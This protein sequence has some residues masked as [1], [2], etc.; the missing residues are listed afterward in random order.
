MNQQ[1]QKLAQFTGIQRTELLS[2]WDEVKANQARLD[3]CQ[4]H[5]FGSQDDRKLGARYAC[6]LCGGTADASAVIWYSR[7][8]AHG[9]GKA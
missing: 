1:L 6:R 7:G 5:D 8:L 2:I 4:R 9:G 3:G